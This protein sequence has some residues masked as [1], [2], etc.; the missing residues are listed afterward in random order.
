MASPPDNTRGIVAMNI[1]MFGFI[2]SDTLVKFL[3]Q[4]LPLG[5]TVFLRGV[6][7][8]ALVAIVVLWT[9][10]WR[11]WRSLFETRMALRIVGELG[12]TVGYLVGLVHMPIANATAVFQATPLV[13]TACAAVFLGEKVGPAR[14]VAIAIGLCGVMV[15]VRPGL[16]GFDVWSLA[17]LAAV[18]SVALRDI[19]TARISAHTPTSLVTFATAITVTGLGLAMMPFEAY[20]GR[21][22]EWTRPTS[23]E[24]AMVVLNALALLGG[25]VGMLV[26]TRLAETSAI[27]PFRY[28][29]LVWAFI[30]GV[31]V[32]GQYPDLPTLIG[33]AIVVVTGLYSFHRERSTRSAPDA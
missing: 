7:A 5:E 3:T 33:A 20:I 16:E 23:F 25:Y 27:A 31:V 15:I 2:G 21:H 4:T 17:I 11:E 13:M 18:A 30:F 10:S 12:A 19:S 24:A 8:S 32:F 14:W 9:G 28:A 1:A 26:A 6:V 29:L 22:V